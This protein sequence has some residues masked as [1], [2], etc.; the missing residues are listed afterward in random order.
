MLKA[1]EALPL[2][3]TI[4]LDPRKPRPAAIYNRS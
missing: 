2:R 4:P 3:E 1:E